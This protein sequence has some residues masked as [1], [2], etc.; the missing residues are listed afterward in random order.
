[1]RKIV[2]IGVVVCGVVCLLL[3]LGKR[4]SHRLE[5]TVHFADAQGL[6]GG[7]PVRLAGVDVGSITSVEVQ[8]DQRQT[9]VEVKMLLLTG[10]DLRIPNDST[11]SLATAGVLGETYAVVNIG[12]AS[13]PPV[14]NH[15]TLKGAVSTD[16][17]ST[18]LLERFADALKNGGC[19]TQGSE[20]NKNSRKV[21]H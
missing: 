3:V 12:T 5:L 15:G 13:G 2:L 17:T 14:Q 10:Y 19:E 7:A 9:P 21:A 4:S 6:R 20:Q 16:L 11:V 18:Q 1:M 8:P